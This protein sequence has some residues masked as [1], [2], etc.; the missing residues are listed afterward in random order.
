VSPDAL[1]LQAFGLTADQIMPAL[2]I[3]GREGLQFRTGFTLQDGREIP[4]TVR[5]ERGTERAWSDLQR[6]RLSTP[7]GVL[8]LGVLADVSRMP[9]PLT[10]LHHDGRREVE[11]TYRLSQ[12]APKTGPLRKALEAQIHSSI[13]KTHRPPGYT[14]E[15]PEEGATFSWFKR[16]LIPIVL[17]LYAVLAVTFESLT[18]PLLVL[19]ALPLTVLGATWALVVADMPADVMALVGAVALIGITVNPAILLVDRMQQH[20]WRGGM[21]AGAA[22]LAAVK[23]R[24]RPVLMTATTTIAGL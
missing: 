5:R 11:V 6:L 18:L 13:R 7:A 16:L 22:A 14:I 21:S 23:E 10:I 12:E 4:L 17:L 8:P 1:A 3:I 15:T 2:N 24:T 19:A 9:A 20:A